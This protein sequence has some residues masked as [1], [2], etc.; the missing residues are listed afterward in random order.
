V[1][2]YYPELLKANMPSLSDPAVGSGIPP[3]LTPY[4]NPDNERAFASR[5]R[6]IFTQALGVDRSSVTRAAKAAY[7]SYRVWKQSVLAEGRRAIAFAREAGRKMIVLA[8]RPYHVDPEIHHGIDA[9]LNAL[10]L[11]VLT[12]DAILEA[13]V[14][15]DVRVLN[16]WTYQSRLYNA[17][18]RVAEEPDMELVQLVSFGCGIDAI[19]TDE[20]RALMERKGR[21]Y[22]Q[23]KID[24]IANLGAVKIRLRSL[25]AAM[26]E[27]MRKS[28]LQD[29]PRVCHAG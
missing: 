11:V 5:A 3:F 6:K 18:A 28:A 12:E 20:T 22:T 2:A 19:T 21:L 1:V 15:Q 29:T 17:A 14:K 26:E 25:L 10:G 4:L 7:A 16:Q 23:I 8:G 24:E 13:P 27:R 9:L